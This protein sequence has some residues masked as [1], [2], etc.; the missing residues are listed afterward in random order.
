MT[1][2]DATFTVLVSPGAGRLRFLPPQRFH[3]GMELV[4]AGQAIARVVQGSGHIIVRAPFAGRVSAVL[5]LEGEPVQ[6]GHAV[7]AIEPVDA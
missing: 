3:R 5:G 2:H 1:K 7:V 6:A 4:E